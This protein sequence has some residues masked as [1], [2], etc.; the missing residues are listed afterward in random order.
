M[1]SVH[2]GAQAK[3]NTLEEEKRGLE[4]DTKVFHVH[5]DEQLKL[6]QS[7][8]EKE[9]AERE[10]LLMK[11]DTLEKMLSEANAMKVSLQKEI[12][13]LTAK[14]QEVSNP[15]FSIYFCDISIFSQ[16]STW[17][18]YEWIPYC[19][20]VMFVSPPPPLPSSPSTVRKW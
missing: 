3:I 9:R 13:V 6:Y 2:G 14:L 17:G 7:D 11:Y 4:E 5:V 19:E 18:I 10:K 12:T 15:H 8:F 1:E 16:E 20:V